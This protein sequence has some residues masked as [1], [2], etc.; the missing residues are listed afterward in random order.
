MN[1]K[2][3]RAEAALKEIREMF[4][5]SGISEAELQDSGRKIRREVVKELYSEKH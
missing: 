2:K 3:V 1:N 4:K 5:A